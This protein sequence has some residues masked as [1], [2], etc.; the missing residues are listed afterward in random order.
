MQINTKKIQAEMKRRRLSL[1]DLG[2]LY[3]PPKK[4]QA[5]WYIV[6]RAGNLATINR[7]AEALEMHAKDLLNGDFLK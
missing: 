6:H 1:E 2:N 7:L 4:R 3:K 5:M